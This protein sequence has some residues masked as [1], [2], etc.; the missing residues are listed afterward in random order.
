MNTISKTYS[1]ALVLLATT[2]IACSGGSS[3]AHNQ[4]VFRQPEPALRAAPPALLARPVRPDRAQA[5]QLARQQEHQAAAPAPEVLLLEALAP[6]LLAVPQSRAAPPRQ[7]GPPLPA[8]P[9][10][11]AAPPAKVATLLLAGPLSAAPP[12]QAAASSWAAPPRPAAPP[13]SAAPP[14]PAEPPRPAE[15]LPPEAPPPLAGQELSVGH[16]TQR[17]LHI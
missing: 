9:P 8:G 16:N 10:L 11:S 4:A 1:V 14:L 7:P 3:G 12:R 17:L 5:I 13:L 15:P 2:A 6:L